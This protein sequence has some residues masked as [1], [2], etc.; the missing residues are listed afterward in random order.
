M[1]NPPAAPAAGP[2]P[3]GGLPAEQERWQEWPSGGGGRSAGRQVFEEPGSVDGVS[4]RWRSHFHR[5]P[6]LH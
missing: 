1:P 5:R 6:H 4:S 2:E 3:S